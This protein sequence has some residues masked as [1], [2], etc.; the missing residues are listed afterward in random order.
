[1]YCRNCGN[2]LRDDA[3]FCD[4]CGTKVEGE[5]KKVS[6]ETPKKQAVRKQVYDGAVH[7]CPNCGHSLDA[8]TLKCPECGYELRGEQSGQPVQKLSEMLQK[9]KT[10]QR[11]NE[12][13]STF[14]IPNTK[15]DIY[16]FFILSASMTGDPACDEAWIAKLEQ[17]Y[18][19]AKVTFGKSEDFA[20]LHNL[21]LKAK[22][23]HGKIQK[24]QMIRRN[25]KIIV[26]LSL[27][28]IGLTLVILGFILGEESGDSDSGYYGMV[29][30]GFFA[31]LGAAY[32]WIFSLIKNDEK[33]KTY[34]NKKKVNATKQE[35]FDEDESEDE[36]EPEDEEED[37]DNENDEDDE[38]EEE[39][40][41]ESADSSVK[42]EFRKAQKQ[43][44][45]S[46][47]NL[48]K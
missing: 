39:D 34:S 14:Y 38:R 9:A 18:L 47:K 35:E 25:L 3:L 42:T 37:E 10:A 26:S 21:Y 36:D 27:F 8:Y 11:R 46:F 45:D 7:K 48:F 4:K 2:K 1:M 40:E 44:K 22:K 13:I 33:K 15:E 43:L 20:E 32:I 28:V 30:G 5:T 31:I 24:K 6:E 23:A 12:L 29:A 19:K 41:S 16:D 17:A